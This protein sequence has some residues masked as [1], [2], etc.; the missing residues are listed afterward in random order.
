MGRDAVDWA[1]DVLELAEAGLRRIGDVNEDGEDEATL[2]RPVRA[3]LE[4]GRCPADL[5]LEEVADEMPSPQAVIG[6][7][8][9]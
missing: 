2:L 9:I 1:G 7:A 5:L 8:R 4:Q 3:L 6:A